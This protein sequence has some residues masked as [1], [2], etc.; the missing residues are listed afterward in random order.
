M[1]QRIS[2]PQDKIPYNNFWQKTANYLNKAADWCNIGIGI[3]IVSNWTS[4]LAYLAAGS[5]YF[6]TVIADPLIYIFRA[7]ARFERIIGRHFFGVKFK[8]E[9]FG[10]HPR[11]TIGDVLSFA[12]FICAAAIFIAFGA[13]AAMAS[14]AP[15]LGWALGILGLSIVVYFDYHH[16]YH[17]AKIKW[18]ELRNKYGNENYRTLAAKGEYSYRKY[19]DWLMISLVGMLA[20]AL[21]CG[22]A[23]T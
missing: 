9:E 4:Q 11:Q 22:S 12:L 18:L 10:I 21:I 8:E 20:L 23:L 16:A 13:G 2:K 7:L 19:A 6:I 5:L 14:F 17:N 1:H 15:T 3:H